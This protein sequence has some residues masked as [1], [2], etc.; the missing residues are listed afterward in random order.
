MAQIYQ[1][2]A[3]S[4]I[5]LGKKACLEV[6]GNGPLQPLLEGV[7]GSRGN[8]AGACFQSGFRIIFAPR[9]MR[10][11]VACAGEKK[12]RKN[13]TFWSGEFFITDTMRLGCGFAQAF[14]A[15]CFKLGV[16]ALEEYHFCV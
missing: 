2:Y 16:V 11:L 14:L 4:E 1:S 9:R 10:Y 15:V 3:R 13:V 12:F 5:A 6:E 7:P 8:A